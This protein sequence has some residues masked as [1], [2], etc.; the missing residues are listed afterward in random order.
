MC[1]DFRHVVKH[2]ASRVEIVWSTEGDQKEELGKRINNLKV[3]GKTQ[4]VAKAV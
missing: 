3:K 2:I 4:F 1:Y